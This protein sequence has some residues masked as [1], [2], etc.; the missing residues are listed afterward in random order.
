MDLLE[1]LGRRARLSSHAAVELASLPHAAVKGWLLDTPRGKRLVFRAVVAQIY[2]TAVEPL[3]LFLTIGGLLGFVVLVAADGLLR[4]LGLAHLGPALCARLV[5]CEL[6]PLVFALVLTGRS[7]TAIAT[8]LGSMRV[9][10]EID[11]LDVLGINV[12]YFVVL[13]RVLGVTIAATAL[14]AVA[15]PVGLG[16]GWLLGRT[17]G[18]LS[19]SIGLFGWLGAIDVV[20]LLEALAKSA[21]LGLTVATINCHHGLGVRRSATEIPKAN[22]RG[23]VQ[24]YLV[25][26]FIA[27]LSS[28]IAVMRSSVGVSR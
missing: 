14:T 6:V 9:N 21:L 5:M 2:F 10:Y 24:A 20:L 4:P 8:E 1:T 28:I 17:L 27:A 18:M 25:C 23:S 7:G 11:A 15:A 16:A 19:P 26:F 12:D 3:S 22:V 13:P